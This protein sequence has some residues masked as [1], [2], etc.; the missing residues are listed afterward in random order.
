M[1]L[2][3][4][5]PLTL[6]NRAWIDSIDEREV[7]LLLLRELHAVPAFRAFLIGKA[8]H[9][10]EQ[11]FV[12]A[13]RGVFDSFGE[14]DVL[15]IS[16]VDQLGRVAVMIEDKIGAVFQ[17]D[18]AA[19]YRIRGDA[20][21]ADGSWAAYRTC[22]VGP[23]LYIDPHL[24]S[25]EW[26]IFV[27]FEDIISWLE[28]LTEGDASALF[29][30]DALKRASGK[31][32]SG[33]F[34]PDA[35]AT[36]FWQR[37]LTICKE[38]FAD[39]GLVSLKPVQSKNEPWPRFAVSRLPVGT[40]L[41]HKAWKGHVDLTFDNQK[42]D[43]VRERIEPSLLTQFQL[44]K[45][46]GSTALRATVSRVQHLESF[47]SQEESVRH[48]LIAARSLMQFATANGLWREDMKA[49]PSD[50]APQPNLLDWYDLDRP[51]TAVVPNVGTVAVV[52]FTLF[53]EG[54][55]YCT[56]GIFD[57]L[58]S[59]FAHHHL[60]GAVTIGEEISCEGTTLRLMREDDDCMDEWLRAEAECIADISD[61]RRAL[62]AP[63]AMDRCS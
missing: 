63:M 23:S 21:V 41:E 62:V 53:E 8:F 32:Q 9:R 55:T 40:R 13:W 48:A 38:E 36:A 27:S 46:G 44:V 28:S 29:F 35:R 60:I 52:A 31:F 30:R 2:G 7:D 45:A 59:G 18:Q 6:Q 37:Y 17:A 39:L 25:A 56:V 50:S 54:L 14:T 49:A 10:N 47:G 26:D 42:I 22:L 12:G 19:R 3:M 20:G 5:P 33:G 11:A 43:D 58:Y 34:V 15:L 51:I 4:G 1:T 24:S 16:D 57:P 61:M